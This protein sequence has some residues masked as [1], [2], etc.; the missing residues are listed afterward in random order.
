MSKGL[1]LISG[2][3]GYIAAVTAKHFLEKGYSVRGTVR[4]VA[5]AQSLVDGPLKP[6][7]STGQLTVVEVPDITV[8]GAFDEAVKGQHG[9]IQRADSHNILTRSQA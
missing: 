5:S 1:V 7:A 2:L 4:K 3:N 6:Y 8:D 9:N